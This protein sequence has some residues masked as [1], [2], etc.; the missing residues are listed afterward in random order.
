MHR[1][2]AGKRILSRISYTTHIHTRTH[3]YPRFQATFASTMTPAQGLHS[4]TFLFRS[5]YPIDKLYFSRSLRFVSKAVRT[6]NERALCV[7]YRVH[8]AHELSVARMV[9]LRCISLHG[10]CEYPRNLVRFQHNVIS[11][12]LSCDVYIY[13][14]SKHNN[15][16]IDC[17]NI[18]ICI[19]EQIVE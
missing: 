3:I 9:H 8:S 19:S 13:L 4:C 11:Y 5:P 18:Y 6:A 2:V 10:S 1:A 12:K 16:S 7:T 15:R 17:C 14:R